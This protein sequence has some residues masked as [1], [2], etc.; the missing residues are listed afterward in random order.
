MA[1][2][3]LHALVL[4][5]PLFGVQWAVIDGEESTE[6]TVVCLDDFLDLFPT[7][8]LLLDPVHP[9][10]VLLTLDLQFVDDHLPCQLISQHSGSLGFRLGEC[11]R[12]EQNNGRYNRCRVVYQPRNR[13]QRQCATRFDPVIH[14]GISW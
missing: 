9:A 7:S 12:T 5:L 10:P 11:V 14:L 13:W 3:P 8:F 2:E 4:F 1:Y 6:R